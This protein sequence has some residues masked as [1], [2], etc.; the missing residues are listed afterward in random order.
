ML[1]WVEIDPDIRIN[2]EIIVSIKFKFVSSV[3]SI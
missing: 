1:N 2:K 3:T